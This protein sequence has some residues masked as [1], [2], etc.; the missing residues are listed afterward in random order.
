MNVTWTAHARAELLDA[1]DYYE[2]QRA[3]LGARF[4]DEVDRAVER[5]L[6]FPHA[7]PR[8]SPLSRRIRTRKFPY[9]LVYQVVGDTT[10][11]LAVMHLHRRPDY[12]RD[13]EISP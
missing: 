10:H 9:G 2:T 5:M 11:I 8:M 1:A 13:R 7:W 6:A 4:L 12:W 3:Q